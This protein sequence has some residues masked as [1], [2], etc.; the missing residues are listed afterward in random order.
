MCWFARDGVFLARRFPIQTGT[1]FHVFG[2]ASSGVHA[3]LLSRVCFTAL[4]VVVQVFALTVQH[5]LQADDL[6]LD[7]S[8]VAG[9]VKLY[10][11]HGLGGNQLWSYSALVCARARACRLT[12]IVSCLR[13]CL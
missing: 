12:V 9:D 2:C 10:Q 13:S 7:V 8:A 5:S 1:C 11:C 3:H 6:C 4:L